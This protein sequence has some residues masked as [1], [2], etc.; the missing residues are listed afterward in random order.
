MLVVMGNALQ[1]AN[2]P[3]ERETPPGPSRAK[4]SKE[5]VYVE[6]HM[7]IN[8]MATGRVKVLQS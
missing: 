4:E 7:S 6:S 3:L 2:Q 1:V 5:I 8:Y